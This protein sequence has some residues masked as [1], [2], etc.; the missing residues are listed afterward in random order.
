MNFRFLISTKN[1]NTQ[2]AQKFKY[3]QLA[4]NHFLKAKFLNVVPLNPTKK[5]EILFITFDF[6]SLTENIN[7]LFFEYLL[8]N[9]FIILTSYIIS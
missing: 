4:R 1:F 6:F 3:C 7:N 2:A 9:T 5:M 8:I